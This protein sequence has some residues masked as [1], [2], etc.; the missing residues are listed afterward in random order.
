MRF[1]ARRAIAVLNRSD[2]DLLRVYAHPEIEAINTP[3]IVALGAFERET[4]GR[5]AFVAAERRWEEQWERF[6]Y[7]PSEILDFGD[8]WFLLL[9]HVK[10][11]GGASGVVVDSEWGLLAKV[12]DGMVIRE[13]N[14]LSRDEAMAAATRRR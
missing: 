3:G 10:A 12:S 11:E 7:E 5:D 2:T 6:R 13:E 8:D 4:R 14:F 9:G 1:F